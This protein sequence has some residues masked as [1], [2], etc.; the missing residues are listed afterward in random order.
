[1]L[2]FMPASEA[3][4]ESGVSLFNPLVRRAIAFRAPKQKHAGVHYVHV[5]LRSS[6]QSSLRVVRLNCVV[7]QL[8]RRLHLFVDGKLFAKSANVQFEQ[9]DKA[10]VFLAHSSQGMVRTVINKPVPS[11]RHPFSG[12]RKQT[13]SSVSV[14]QW[15]RQG[16]NLQQSLGLRHF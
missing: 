4:K 10:R 3:S 9:I 14:S 11:T 16:S 12:F 13:S 5:V 2:A 1:M 8:R 6:R 7:K 15:S